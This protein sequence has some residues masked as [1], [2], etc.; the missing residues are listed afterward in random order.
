[1]VHA[2][3][4]Y[5]SR[6]SGTDPGRVGPLWAADQATRIAQRIG[7]ILRRHGRQQVYAGRPSTPSSPLTQNFNQAFGQRRLIA[8]MTRHDA[9]LAMPRDIVERYRGQALSGLG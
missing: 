5:A 4:G 7:L 8:A 3:R 1:V 2:H 9:D 6:V